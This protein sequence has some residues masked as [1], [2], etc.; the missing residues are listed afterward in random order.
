[1]EQAA[2]PVHLSY[3]VLRS[4]RGFYTPYLSRDGYA[5]YKKSMLKN[6]PGGTSTDKKKEEKGKRTR[7]GWK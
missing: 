1:M 7:P 6:R 3:C 2:D 5:E 4:I